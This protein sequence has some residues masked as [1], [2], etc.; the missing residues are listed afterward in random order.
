MHNCCSLEV[1]TFIDPNPNGPMK[2]RPET[3]PIRAII[4]SSG[5]RTRMDPQYLDPGP[6]RVFSF[7]PRTEPSYPIRTD[8][9]YSC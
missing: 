7:R 9:A 6:T 8:T 5:V 2:I 3:D 1:S 4:I